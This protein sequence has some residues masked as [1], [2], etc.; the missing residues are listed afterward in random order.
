MSSFPLKLSRYSIFFIAGWNISISVAYF[1]MCRFSL[2]RVIAF[3]SQ[4][5][6]H[7]YFKFASQRSA[8]MNL[9][10]GRAYY[11]EFEFYDYGGQ[12]GAEMAVVIDNTRK[13]ASQVAGAYNEKQAI[14]IQSVYLEEKQ[15]SLFT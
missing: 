14:Q 6:R 2:Q 8:K 3:A 11:F 7:S 12:Y 15:V 9:T 4:F 10:K 5:T 13:T 1:Y